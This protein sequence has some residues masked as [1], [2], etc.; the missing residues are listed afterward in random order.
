MRTCCGTKATLP[1]ISILPFFLSISP[2]SA[3]SSEDLPEPTAPTWK[4]DV[5][6]DQ[7]KYDSRSPQRTD[8]L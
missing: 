5:S 7:V 4:S 3:K 6:T 1:E 8:C 2:S